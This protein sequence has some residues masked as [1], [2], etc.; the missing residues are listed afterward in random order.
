MKK[1]TVILIIVTVAIV[2]IGTIAR[3]SGSSVQTT[4]WSF[5]Q[6]GW[7]YRWGT[8]LLDS[9]GSPLW[10]KDLS[11]AGW[12]P[13]QFPGQPPGRKDEHTL[14]LKVDI[15]EKDYTNPTI[16]AKFVRQHFILYSNG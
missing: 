14:W 12:H 3:F 9:A 13:M 6:D 1:G 5:I 4:G 2:L 8:S 10:A 16:F 15:P 7:Q 11:D